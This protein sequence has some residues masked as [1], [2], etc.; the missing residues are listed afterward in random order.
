VNDVLVAAPLAPPMVQI[1]RAAN[2]KRLDDTAITQECTDG[3]T[4]ILKLLLRRC[5][6]SWLDKITALP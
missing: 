5:R 3:G 6:R 1:I 4:E 2:G